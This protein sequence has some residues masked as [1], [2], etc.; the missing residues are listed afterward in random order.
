MRART[1]GMQLQVLVRLST[2]QR[3]RWATQPRLW[4]RRPRIL[5]AALGARSK[6]R[7]T[8]LAWVNRWLHTAAMCYV[9][10]IRWILPKN[11]R[12]H[13]LYIQQWIATWWSS[14]I[15]C[16]AVKDINLNLPMEIMFLRGGNS[17]WM[18]YVV[19]RPYTRSL[20]HIVYL[21]SLYKEDSSI[22]AAASQ[23]RRSSCFNQCFVI[24]LSW[25]ILLL[26]PVF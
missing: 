16:H 23:Q 20:C 4:E 6:Q 14:E 1:W 5:S 3:A 22:G 21:S 15:H 19:C 13:S 11:W 12:W 24:L 26:I 10:S 9:T 8:P 2:T 25:L 7:T 18:H 17:W